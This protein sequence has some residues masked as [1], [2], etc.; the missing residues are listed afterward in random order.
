MSK[1]NDGNGPYPGGNDPNYQVQPTEFRSSLTDLTAKAQQAAVNVF[2]G[3]TGSPG[4]I[5]EGATSEEVHSIVQK[6]VKLLKKNLEGMKIGE[7]FKLFKEYEG[8]TRAEFL[9]AQTSKV[10]ICLT[11][12]V[13]L[14]KLKA[15]VRAD[16]KS[17]GEWAAKNIRMPAK[18][19]ERYMAIANL[20]EAE[21]YAYLGV[22]RLVQL[23]GIIKVEKRKAA[24]S[25][26]TPIS[27]LLSNQAGLQLDDPHL[28]LEEFSRGVDA[29]VWRR[30]L[31]NKEI[32]LPIQLI[33]DFLA[34]GG[35]FL[36]ADLAVMTD[37]EKARSEAGDN[38][39]K[40]RSAGDYLLEVIGANGNRDGLEKPKALSDTEKRSA[41]LLGTTTKMQQAIKAIM[42]F[43]ETPCGIDAKT[44]KELIKDLRALE[45]RIAS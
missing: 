15:L 42:D 21:R 8:R 18:T 20:N 9:D 31:K 12:G 45:K 6:E 22:E 24:L 19:R 33:I 39:K 11:Y 13:I 14:N 32:D 4:G 1:K 3:A 26:T 40:L 30:K 41:F 25:D 17:W 36:S 43:D 29:L 7:V 23:A 37:R 28:S 10:M 2:T 35:D 38:G 44:I 16:D 34:V 27:D 5:P